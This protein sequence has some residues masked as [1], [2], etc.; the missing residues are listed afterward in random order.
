[1]RRVD[2][3]AFVASIHQQLGSTPVRDFAVTRFTMS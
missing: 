1:V 3:L 2:D